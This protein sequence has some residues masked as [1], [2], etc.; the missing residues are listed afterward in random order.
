MEM[1]KDK[2]LKLKPKSKTLT[3]NNQKSVEEISSLRIIAEKLTI[4]EILKI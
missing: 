3:L 2:K 4:Q 1:L